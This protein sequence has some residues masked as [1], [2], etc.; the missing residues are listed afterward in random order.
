M[1]VYVCVVCFLSVCVSVVECVCLGVYRCVCV[2]V[3]VPH[4]H[5]H[6]RTHT[7]TV[8]NVRAAKVNPTRQEAF[9]GN[10]EGECEDLARRQ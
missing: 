9:Q 3:C 8:Q 5:T 2:C 7:C 4:S 1:C 6:T 10:R